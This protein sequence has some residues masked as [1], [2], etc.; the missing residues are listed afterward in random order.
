M[1]KHAL[2]LVPDGVGVRNFVLGRFLEVLSQLTAAT[3]VLH[4]IPDQLVPAYASAT[5]D[6]V[7]WMPLQSYEESAVSST[8]RY[9]LSYAQMYWVGTRSMRF[10]L[11]MSVKGSWRTQ[12]VHQAARV[13]GRLA[14]SPHGVRLLERGHVTVVQRSS[15]FSYYR[16]WLQ[17]L[18]PTVLFSTHQRPVGI[19]PAV[20]AARSLNVPTA[21]FIFSWDNLSSKG[22]MASPFDHYF[23]WSELMRD[24]LLR[25]YPDVTPDR[26][27]VVGTPQFDPYEDR[28]LLLSR[29]AFFAQFGADPT[30]PLICYSGGDSSSSPEDPQHVAVLLAA[31]RAGRIIRRAQ[32][33]LRPSPVDPGTRYDA[34]RREFPELIYAP[35]AWEH[36]SGHWGQVLPRMEDV[37]LLANLTAHADLNVNVASTMTLDF[38]IRDKPVVNV[39]FDVASPPPFGLPLWDHH[40][41]FEHYRPVIELGA[42]RFARSP[43]ELE[44]H[45]N[46]YLADPSLDREGRRRLLDL[47]VGRPIGSSCRLIAETLERISAA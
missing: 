39:A 35:P 33:L 34:V 46:A 47:Q 12:A 5:G 26:V 24:E 30:R 36:T 38:A 32:V 19:V 44:A 23:V 28:T 29:D 2:V 22:R 1:S 37:Q 17:E 45:V 11:N 13:S 21:T 10:N 31:V 20:L 18:R 41:Q 16:R 14:A 43:V 7:R 27:H 6:R 15:Q 42:A 3:T 25:F 8:L 40:Y 4:S 9:A